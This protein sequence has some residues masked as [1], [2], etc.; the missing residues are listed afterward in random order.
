VRSWRLHNHTGL[1]FAEVAGLI[2]PIV[3]GCM[4]YYGAFYRSALYP[5]LSRINDYLVRWISNRYERLQAKRKA[6]RCLRDHP[7][8]PTHVRALG[9]GPIGAC[10]LVIRMTRAR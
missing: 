3:R 2:N 1:D 4:Q 8:I 5:L 9:L 7:T 10:C 6:F